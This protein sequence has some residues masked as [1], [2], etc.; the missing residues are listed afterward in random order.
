[1]LSLECVNMDLD[2]TCDKASVHLICSLT[3]MET[4][5]HGLSLH[6]QG[7]AHCLPTPT[8][9]GKDGTQIGVKLARETSPCARTPTPLVTMC[10]LPVIGGQLTASDIRHRCDPT[11]LILPISNGTGYF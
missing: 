1:M 11:A 3:T 6:L 10:F 7:Q 4:C 9:P 2:N 5:N 8:S